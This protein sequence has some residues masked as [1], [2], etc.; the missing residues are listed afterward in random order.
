MNAHPAVAYL[1]AQ[2]MLDERREEA[3]LHNLAK[4]AGIGRTPRRR[5]VSKKVSSVPRTV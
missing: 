5:V 2:N 1:V 3:R 4:R